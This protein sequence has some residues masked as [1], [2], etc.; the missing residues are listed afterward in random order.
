MSSY[1]TF[2]IV[3]KKTIKKYSYSQENGNTETEIKVSEGLPLTLM[4]YSR[5]NDVYQAYYET[6]NPAYA[7]MEEKYTEVTHEDAQRV[8]T[9]FE[10]EIK[11]TE[12]RLAINYK[13]LKEG[14]YSSE[15]WEEIHSS[16]SYLAEQKASLE[17]LKFISNLIYEITEQ[18]GDFEKV[19]INID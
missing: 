2:Y 18:Y 5:S 15:L 10:R 3:P 12:Q 17:E 4:S 19:L 6:L 8:V 1:L 13:M 9:E 16:E 11:S 7:G 14:G